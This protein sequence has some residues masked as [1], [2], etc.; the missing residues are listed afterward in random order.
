[1]A[2]GKAP[3][4]DGVIVEFFLCMWSVISKDYTKM[5]PN[6]IVKSNFLPRVTKRVIT[7]LQNVGEKKQFFIWRPITLLNVTYMIFAK[8]FQVQMQSV[9]MEAISHD[10][11]TFLPFKFISTILLIHETIS[12][13]KRLNN[14]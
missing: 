9:L 5:I 1:M 12:W 13:A 4:L 7:L 6:S 11:L 14:L 8:T 10:Q 2:K 3:K